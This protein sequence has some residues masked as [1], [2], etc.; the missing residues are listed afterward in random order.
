MLQIKQYILKLKNYTVNHKILV[1]LKLH[2]IQM[3][4]ISWTKF[5]HFN[6]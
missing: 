6:H 2:K 4:D 1:M 3:S 5:Q